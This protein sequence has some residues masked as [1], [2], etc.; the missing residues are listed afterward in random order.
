MQAG[1]R[2]QR[3]QGCAA[4]EGLDLDAGARSGRTMA[5]GSSCFREDLRQGSKP[6]GADA[7][8]LRVREPGPEGDAQ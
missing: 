5:D 2:D 4:P 7:V 3:R 1:D 6:D 8:R